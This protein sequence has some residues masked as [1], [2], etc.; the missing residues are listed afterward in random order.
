MR[1]S[2][3]RLPY[4]GPA[5]A[6]DPITLQADRLARK[7]AQPGYA[8]VLLGLLDRQLQT[9]ADAEHG[10]AVG[11]AGAERDVVAAHA[12]ALHRGACR[13]DPRQ[14]GEIGVV[15]VGSQLG[16]ETAER[17]LDRAHVAGAVLADR[18][19]HNRPF[20]DGSP[21]PSRAVATRSAR[22]RALNAASAV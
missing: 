9:E 22:P 17:D 1:S 18:D 16:A 10:A 6:R 5:D 13:A 20:V 11:V 14:D 19:S 8:A 2:S 15:D 7:E 4:C 3:G 21:A 12:Q